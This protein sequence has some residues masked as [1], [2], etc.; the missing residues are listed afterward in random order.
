MT[1]PI[2]LFDATKVNFTI[3]WSNV[4]CPKNVR[5]PINCSPQGGFALVFQQ[6]S[7]TAL[8]E[9]RNNV[10]E[11]LGYDGISGVLAFEFDTFAS[12]HND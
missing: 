5:N 6:E 12:L 11:G 7:Q 1:Y 9:F 8:G 2:S 4:I 10:G 3:E